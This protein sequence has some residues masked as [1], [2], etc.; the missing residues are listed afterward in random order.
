VHDSAQHNK[1]LHY[2]IN[3]G[4]KSIFLRCSCCIK[5]NRNSWQVWY[6]RV[7]PGADPHHMVHIYAPTLP[8]KIRPAPEKLSR[9]THFDTEPIFSH[10]RPPLLVR[11]ILAKPSLDRTWQSRSS[12]RGWLKASRVTSTT[13]SV[14][15]KWQTFYLRVTFV[16]YLRVPSNLIIDKW[17]WNFFT[18]HFCLK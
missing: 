7:R 16:Y 4:R 15:S 2:E 5:A 3:C 14:S 1:L 9:D 8:L 18:F 6:L 17:Q 13:S 11:Y 12:I 10:L